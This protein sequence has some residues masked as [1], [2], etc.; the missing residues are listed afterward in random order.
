MI[1][2]FFRNLERRGVA[3]LLISGQASVLYGAATFSE[4]IDLWI[5]PSAENLARFRSALVEEGARYYKL[6]PPLELPY[7]Q[8]GHGFHFVLGSAEEMVFLDVMGR[9]PRVRDFRSAQRNGR[10]FATDWGNLL[11]IGIPDLVELKKTQRLADYPIISA[12][13]LRW[14]EERTPGRTELAWAATNLFTVESFFTFNERFPAWPESGP[15]D[16]PSSLAEW[17]GHAMETVPEEIVA[18]AE[19]W[20]AERMARHQ[21]TDRQYWKSIIAELRDLRSRRL[22]AEEGAR[23]SF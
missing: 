7:L 5:E 12:L 10:R 11:T 15:N 1:A 17:A 6:T 3:S 13:T 20:M 4:D 2:S 14:L 22:L 8:S 21:R 9:P 18:E 23:V 16:I 19:R